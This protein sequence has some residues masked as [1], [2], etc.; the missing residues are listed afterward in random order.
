[1]SRSPS[2]PS[3]FKYLR[4]TQRSL[5]QDT[6]GSIQSEIIS[7]ERLEQHARSLATTHIVTQRPTRR[8]HLTA[9]LRDNSRELSSAYRSI[10]D[11]LRKKQAIAP[12]VEWLV[13]NFHLIEDQIRDIRNVLSSGYFKQLPTLAQGFLEG[14]PRVFAI[15][16][17]YVSHSD[18]RFDV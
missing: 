6:D 3:I 14:Y 1:M 5:L 18:S 17:A 11:A 15:T 8:C 9:R 16:W 12:A 7:P 2:Q 13:D 10:A 4:L